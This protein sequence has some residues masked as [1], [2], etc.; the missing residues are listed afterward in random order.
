MK[1]LLI[2]GILLIG[3]QL[4][5]AEFNVQRDNDIGKSSV[6]AVSTINV[7]ISTAGSILRSITLSGV[8]PTTITVINAQIFAV[9]ASTKYQVYWPGGN[10]ALPVTVFPGVFNSSGTLIHKDGA[11]IASYNWDWITKPTYVS[12]L[13]ER[14]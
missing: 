3:S 8:A 9:D 13:N 14:N 12:P 7:A 5:H 11:C 1:K 6:S 4:C 2:A 10:T